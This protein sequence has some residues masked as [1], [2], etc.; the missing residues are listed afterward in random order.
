VVVRAG[1]D[2]TRPWLESQ[3]IQRADILKRCPAVDWWWAYRVNYYEPHGWVDSTIYNPEGYR[4]YR[5]AVYLNGA[6]FLEALRGQVGETAFF[7]TLRDYAAIYAHRIAT[8]KDFFD[9]LDT[10]T[11]V[12]YSEV[13]DTY[14]QNPP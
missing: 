1:N 8:G 5:S 12:D 14:F 3:H 2:Q 13:V 6:V 7:A 11:T 10:H 4:A 9:V